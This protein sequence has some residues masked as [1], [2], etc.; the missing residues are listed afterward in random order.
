MTFNG[1]KKEGVEFLKQLELNNTKVWFENNRHIWEENILKP[2]VAFVEEMGETL[3]ILVPTIK[4]KPKVSGSLFKIYRD[5][6]FSKDKTPMKDK[7]GI[8]FWQGQA[9]RMQSASY[10]F[11]FNTQMYYIAT[12]IRTFKPPLLKAYRKYIQNKTNAMNLHNIL[13]DIKQKGYQT[14]E[15]KYKRLPQGFKQEDEYS[16]LSKYNAIFGFQTYELDDTFYSEEIV[17]KAF[18]VFQDMDELRQ[19]LYELTLTVED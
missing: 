13:Q 15:P 4:A 5:T 17:D 12:G 7:I 2:N 10:Y 16:Y 18:K 9:H 3:E 11:F 6:R 8:I 14:P 1:F 19:W